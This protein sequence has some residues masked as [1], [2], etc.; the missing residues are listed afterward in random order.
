MPRLQ[1]T[2]PNALY[3]Y[4]MMSV[5]LWA[6][7]GSRFLGRRYIDRWAVVE[8]GWRS[9]SSIWVERMNPM[10]VGSFLL[11]DLFQKRARVLL[12]ISSLSHWAEE[13]AGRNR[14]MSFNRRPEMGL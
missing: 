10:R 4:R 7:H 1:W 2:S 3:G 6:S 8:R 5:F 14:M 12:M 11:W 13:V 9:M